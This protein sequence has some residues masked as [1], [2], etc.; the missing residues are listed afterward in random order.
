[1]SAP[2]TD[3]WV[4]DQNQLNADLNTWNSEQ[5]AYV[6]AIQAYHAGMA[7]IDGTSD[8]MV[9][10]T[11]LAW[12]MA[13]EGSNQLNLETAGDGGDLKIQGDLTKLGN[14]LEDET[15]V[16]TTSMYDIDTVAVHAYQLSSELSAPATTSGPGD[17][18]NVLGDPAGQLASQYNLI[19]GQIWDTNPDAGPNGP[20]AGSNWYFAGTNDYPTPSPV[21]GGPITSYAQFQTDLQTAGDPGQANEAENTSTTQS[22]NA[23]SQEII[24]NDSNMQ[25]AVQAFVVDMFHAVMDVISAANKASTKA[26]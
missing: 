19:R 15:N 16:D 14:D 6:Q 25:K 5:T 9:A 13:N 26:S 11:M 20:V 17:L 8:A 21:A 18:Q 7:R 3:T 1:M 4:A 12:L 23:S 22:T 2:T 10:F 24:S